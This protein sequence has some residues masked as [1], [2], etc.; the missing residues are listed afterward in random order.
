MESSPENRL[1][2]IGRLTVGFGIVGLVRL[3]PEFL[4]LRSVIP[5][6][7]WGLV[8]TD[9]F[10]GIVLIRAGLKLSRGLVVAVPSAAG[11]WS[12]LLANS[13]PIFTFALPEFLRACARGSTLW[14]SASGR[15]FLVLFPRF[16]FYA[17]AAMV[18]P[19]VFWALLSRRFP[20]TQLRGETGGAIFWG[21]LG[22][23]LGTLLILGLTA[24][25]LR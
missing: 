1:G 16:L 12:A 11:A 14:T 18:G 25:I 8:L 9:I 6:V 10:L 2:L 22:S 21:L 13:L 20:S 4:W 5:P 15:E 24:A 17:F 3:I 19:L 7:Y 23:P